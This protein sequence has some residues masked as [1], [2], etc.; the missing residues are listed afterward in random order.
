MWEKAW[1]GLPMVL[2]KLREE[3]TTARSLSGV[4][5][6]MATRAIQSQIVYQPTLLNRLLDWRQHPT[7]IELTS[8]IPMTC[9]SEDSGVH[10]I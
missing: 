6:I 1:S 2:K 7:P 8:S 4:T 9:P 10:M 3:V 5:A